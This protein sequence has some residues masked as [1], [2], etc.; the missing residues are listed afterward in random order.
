MSDDSTLKYPYMGFT[1]DMPE[2]EAIK[3]FR[4]KYHAEPAEVRHVPN[5][6]LVGPLP[7]DEPEP[8]SQGRLI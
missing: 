4:E 6:L 8:L 1:P 3:R 7:H 2:A 5:L